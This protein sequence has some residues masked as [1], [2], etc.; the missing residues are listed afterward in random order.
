MPAAGFQ[1]ANGVVALPKEWALFPC[2]S[3]VDCRCT[4]GR[5]DCTSPGKHPRTLNGLNDASRDPKQQAEWWARWPQ[6]NLAIATGEVNG[7][8]VIDI[9]PAKG[10]S[11]SLAAV[12]GKHGALPETVEVETG[13]GGLHLY[14]RYPETVKVHSRNGWRPGVDVK[15][16]GGYVISPPS[17]HA[18]GGTYRWAEG[19]K[20]GEIEFAEIPPWLLALLPQKCEQ[21][22]ELNH[23]IPSI[24]GHASLL[25]RAQ[26]YV[27]KA[28][29]TGK[30]NRNDT[31]F[32]LAGNVAA[33]S[34]NGSR[35]S[36]GEI[37]SV[38]SPWNLRNNPP[39][40]ESEL[41]QCVQSAMRNGQPRPTKEATRHV[42]SR[43]EGNGEW[44]APPAPIEQFTFGELRRAYP[45]LH[46]PV[47]DGLIR[48]GETCNVISTSKVGKSWLG[49]GMLLS[50]IT[51]RDW[52]GRFATSA[53]RVLLIDNELHRGTLANRIPAVAGEVGVAPADYEQHLHV[54]PL[55]GSL[56][57]LANLEDE[58]ETIVAGTY[59]LIL[60]DA[61]YRFN[62]AGVSENDNAAMAAMYNTL[63][64]I[65]ERTKAAI[66]LIHHATKGSQSE[67][68]VTDVGAGAGAQSRAADCHLIL[69]E[70]EEPGV[71]VL[72]AAVR[73]FAPVEPLAL[74]WQFPLW[75]PVAGIDPTRLK[76][77]LTQSE[78]RQGERDREGIDAI[79]KALNDGPAT[80]SQL[81]RAGLGKDRLLRLLGILQS[82]GRVT[83]ARTIVKGNECDEYRLA[84]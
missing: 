64:R 59:K 6:A 12:E 84:E 38:L 70:H 68:R 39:L 33:L 76:G 66:V 44:S 79:T 54:W 24:N 16:D 37:L 55:R 7:V 13:G 61:L 22:S 23:A 78:Q 21:P 5:S 27:A 32:R 80:A 4:C 82:Q 40:A 77:R 43:Y 57:T 42:A 1:P 49:Y 75:V 74:Q 15:A 19:R 9:D 52:L 46:P 51:G 58:F 47:I 53:G 31:A 60:L 67:K 83:V 72:E 20:P 11:E 14:F 30:G 45:R 41:R 36:E 81:R 48:E 63:D 50:V 35:L 62:I 56:R 17:K 73:S 34:G 2:H 26:A 28:A 65:A 29:A 3:I 8:V 71:V 10:G 18:S 25:Q 69:R